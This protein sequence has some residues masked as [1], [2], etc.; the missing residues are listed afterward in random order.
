MRHPDW[1]DGIQVRE[2]EVDSLVIIMETPNTV[3]VV[4][5]ANW[6]QL[7]RRQRQKPQYPPVVMTAWLV[8]RSTFSERKWQLSGSVMLQ[9]PTTTQL[10]SKS[11]LSNQKVVVWK[12]RGQGCVGH[13]VDFQN[14][15][16]DED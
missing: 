3:Q 4:T 14:N 13:V 16:L 9:V 8:K 10:I 1:D 2:G 5:S 6:L 7:Q 12:D 15:V 11:I